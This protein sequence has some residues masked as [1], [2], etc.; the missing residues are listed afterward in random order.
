M[1]AGQTSI[2]AA[3]GSRLTT[4]LGIPAAT[5][6][7]DQTSAPYGNG[8]SA[9]YRAGCWAISTAT[10][11]RQGAAGGDQLDMRPERRTERRRPTRLA[12]SSMDRHIV[13][14]M[15]DAN[16]APEE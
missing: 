11:C 13:I 8:R 14:P 7:A 10:W 16:L 6:A 9:P 3:A 1:E 4:N 5:L 2:P 15:P 12:K